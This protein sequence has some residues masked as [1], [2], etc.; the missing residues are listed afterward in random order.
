M[1]RDCKA[2]RPAAIAAAVLAVSL[3]LM[4]LNA[5]AAGAHGVLPAPALDPAPR[6]SGLQTA[7]FAGGCFWGV[8]GVFEHVD[9]VT[10]A[11]SGY[12][13]GGVVDPT[14]EQVSAGTTGHTESVRVTFDPTRVSYGRL[15]QIFFTVAL[16]P[17]LVDRQGPDVGTQ[18]RSELFV[19]DPLQAQ[20]AQSY[21]QQLDAAHVFD[22]PIA[23]RI[24]AAGPFYSAEARHQ[25]YLERHPNEPYIVAN[26]MP[27]VRKLQ[28]LFPTVY[29]ST[30][31]RAGE[32]AS[33]N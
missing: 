2:T 4:P 15:L 9:G 25:D 18:Y 3:S 20:I 13:G 24:N 22:G 5:R 8:Q 16:D 31:V 10:N 21:V 14:Y 32:L 19:S 11:V 6:Q 7:T 28:T 29:Q 1:V 30:P 17:T 12:A 27:K 26:D 33:T 23:T